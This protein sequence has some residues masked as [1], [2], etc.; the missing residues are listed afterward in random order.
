MTTD[1]EQKKMW[2]RVMVE[3]FLLTPRDTR[4]KLDSELAKRVRDV[5]CA[6]PA[7]MI[8]GFSPM[9]DEPDLSYF[10]RIWLGGGG[11]LALP[12]WLGGD[13]MILR[14]VDDLDHQLRPG[15]GG[16]MEPVETQPEV[17]PEQLDVVII[18]GRAFSE[19]LDRMGRGAGSYD[20]LFR[21][22]HISR[23]GVA[24]DFQIFPVIPTYEGDVPMHMIVTP[25][26]LLKAEHA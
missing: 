4:R 23:I 16:I 14:K 26:R 24:Y 21:A 25:A 6:G 11:E 1:Q 20:A 12:V 7:K 18:P 8:M 17:V 5:V 9:A 13:K 10:Y 15:R 2:R 19:R 3:L 22:G